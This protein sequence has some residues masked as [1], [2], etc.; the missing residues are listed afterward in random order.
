MTR[1]EIAAEWLATPNAILRALGGA[2]S[3]RDKV[4]ANQFKMMHSWPDFNEPPFGLEFHFRFE[5][6][7][8]NASFR[9]SLIKRG[10]YC[11]QIHRIRYYNCVVDTSS[12]TLD[13][14]VAR[15]VEFAL[16]PS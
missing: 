5:D 13:E 1:E 4:G 14:A 7:E 12:I 16:P 3:L 15:F 8:Y 9:T 11:L 6:K 2:K 10:K